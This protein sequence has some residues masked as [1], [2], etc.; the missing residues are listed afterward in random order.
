MCR[1]LAASAH[2]VE[3]LPIAHCESFAT[4]KRSLQNRAGSN[5]YKPKVKLNWGTNTLVFELSILLYLI[6][7]SFKVLVGWNSSGRD[8]AVHLEV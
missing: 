2:N 3:K 8:L 4:F 5:E 1:K 6:L 7:H